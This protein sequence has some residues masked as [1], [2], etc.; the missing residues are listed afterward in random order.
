ME[1][2]RRKK[3]MYASEAKQLSRSIGAGRK[4][5]PICVWCLIRYTRL[6]HEISLNPA[7]T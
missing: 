5:G 7:S 3:V 4:K 6:Y 2:G 1:E